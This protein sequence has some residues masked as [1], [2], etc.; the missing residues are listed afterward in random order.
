MAI[1][2]DSNISVKVWLPQPYSLGTKLLLH[3]TEA[4]PFN[5]QLEFREASIHPDN[6]AHPENVALAQQAIDEEV[7]G[8]PED[9]DIEVKSVD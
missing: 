2:S 6:S 8:P 3:C 7:E 9:T 5:Q 1:L 4:D